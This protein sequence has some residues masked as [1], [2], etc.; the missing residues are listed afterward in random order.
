MTRVLVRALVLA[1]AFVPSLAVVPGSANAQAGVGAADEA[2]RVA[3][4]LSVLEAAGDFNAL[5]D[6]IHPDAHA[7]IP[8]SVVTGWFRDYYTGKETAE[9]TVTDARIVTWTWAV[10]GVTYPETMEVSFVQPLWEDG[11]YAE[12][13]DVVRLVRDGRGEWRWFFG[14]SRAFVDEQIAR[15]VT[16]VF[17]AATGDLVETV[18][19][20]LDAFWIETFATGPYRYASPRVSRFDQAA[21]TGC[22]ATQPG[23]TGPF[24][25]RSDGGVYLDGPFLEALSTRGDFAVAV[26]IAHEW[27]HHVQGQLGLVGSLAPDQIGE[28]YPIQLELM[29]DCL[30][31][32][33]MLDA[34]TRGLLAPGDV[35]EAMVVTLAAGDVPGTS[36]FDPRAHG[37]SAERVDAFLTGYLS[38]I[39]GCLPAA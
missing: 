38:G 32:V 11:A 13:E 7:V 4:E 31:G 14:R 16:P 28:F 17:A 39:T 37:S 18:S 8:R 1:V 27:A 5:Y 3:R 25:C 9:V 12:I 34:D 6:R 29:A 19:A 30:A 26:V 33:W 36:P 2:A 15:Y 35:E 22:G 23:T 20:D 21:L 24:Y 10:T